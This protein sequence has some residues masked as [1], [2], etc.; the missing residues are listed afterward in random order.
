MKIKN[1]IIENFI[2]FLINEKN[3]DEVINI[4]INWNV[5]DKV[6]RIIENN[7]DKIVLI[8]VVNE[9]LL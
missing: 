5:Y 1:E 9:F 7:V 3:Y 2:C 6:L 4:F 8:K